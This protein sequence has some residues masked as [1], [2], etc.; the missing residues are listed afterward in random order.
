MDAEKAS[1]L[2]KKLFA[3]MVRRGL[4]GQKLSRI[5]QV[6]DSEVSRILAGKSRPGL[7][8]AFRLSRAVGVSLDFLADDSL[9]SDP[10]QSS[11][12]MSAEQREILDLAQG[13]GYTR[14]A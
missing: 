8:N 10:A 7:E 12:P 3:Q 11:D 9:E 4:N 6:S 5:S 1:P 13:I 2:Q 14:A